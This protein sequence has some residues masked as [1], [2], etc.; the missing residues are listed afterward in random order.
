MYEPAHK[1]IADLILE[2]A[3]DPETR[4]EV[5]LLPLMCG[6][7]K[8]TAISEL[9]GKTIREADETH[10]GILI[11]TD[12]VDR[13]YD[14]LRPYDRELRDYLEENQEKITIISVRNY[15]EAKVLHHRTPVLMMTTQRY[16]RLSI[17]EIENYLKWD[18]GRRELIL[19]DERP[20]LKTLIS[21]TRK[22]LTESIAAT[23]NDQELFGL[24]QISWGTEYPQKW[25]EH[26]D[27]LVVDLTAHHL[28]DCCFFWAPPV[29]ESVYGDGETA[30]DAIF[31]D[32][33]AEIEALYPNAYL[34]LRALLHMEKKMAFVYRYKGQ[35]RIHTSLN[36]LLDNTSLVNLVNAKVIVLDGTADLSPEYTIDHYDM[37][38]TDGYGRRL[39]HLKIQII[40][41]PTSKQR[42]SKE[43][44]RT[45]IKAT[46]AER[47]KRC[48]KRTDKVAL[49]SYQNYLYLFEDLLPKS[50]IEY[51]GNI[52]GKNNFREA[53]HIFQVGL[54][55]Y[56]G[57]AYYLYALAH[58]P[59]E[60][61]KHVNV[62][63]KKNTELSEDR[64]YMTIGY[65]DGAGNPVFDEH[66][67]PIIRGYL[68]DN[69]YNP[70]LIKQE[71]E[72]INEEMLNYG[73][74]TRQIMLRSLLAELEQN[75]FRGV[76]R[77]S[78]ST[79]NFTFHLFINAEHYRDLIELMKERYIPLGASIEV[80]E[81]P[82]KIQLIRSARRGSPNQRGNSINRIIEWHDHVLD[83]GEE[84]SPEQL[85]AACGLSIGV[86]EN[87]RHRHS[88]LTE[89]MDAEKIKRGIYQKKSQWSETEEP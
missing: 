53:N 50:Q 28:N 78:D 82:T 32:H 35:M 26:F 48:T 40:N 17:T 21:L 89:M 14:Y 56:P 8:S 80:E 4:Y 24:L 64:M 71:T 20:E 37:R 70:N 6:T 66:G 83:I 13:M 18:E 61:E 46:V 47:M 85:R 73:T 33:R 57:Q 15:D 5:S 52:V 39:D 2:V 51:F 43:R 76:I 86:Y 36:C 49:F 42:F 19:I 58:H 29:S 1:S 77:N 84:Y 41:L 54:N 81:I 74:E 68:Y 12:R 79:E 60:Q 65:A 45:V 9:I 59:G 55:R 10:N 75:M 69:G 11:I 23:Y 27:D 3:A 16:F 67:Q 63:L 7:G 44:A 34:N 72:L 38:S 87:I 30:V 31:K 22:D 88:E 62:E 25:L